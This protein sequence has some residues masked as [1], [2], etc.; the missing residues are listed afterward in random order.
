MPMTC[1]V[2]G[3]RNRASKKDNIQYFSFPFKDERR[4]MAWINAINRPQWTPT[5]NSRICSQHFTRN[6]YLDRPGGYVK[7]LKYNA[8]PS[9]FMSS[10]ELQQKELEEKETQ[11]I[12]KENVDPNMDIDQTIERDNIQINISN[13]DCS[14]TE[15]SEENVASPGPSYLVFPPEEFSDNN[16]I[17]SD[18]S[19]DDNT[20]SSHKE[21]KL[22]YKV[23]ILQQQ[24]RRKNKKIDSLKQLLTDLK[25]QGKIEDDVMHLVSNEF[26]G[27]PFEIFKNQLLNCKETSSKAYRY[28]DAVKQFALTLHF[29]SPKAYQYCRN[30]GLCLPN[31]SS[32]RN[33]TM[34]VNAEPGF[35]R[36][37]FSALKQLNDE[38]RDCNLVFDSMAI[39]KQVMWDKQC[40]KYIGYCN[41][42][43][44]LHL[45]G[46]DT[47]ATEALVF[48]LVGINGKW[49]WPIGY[50]F[51]DKIKAVIQAELIKTALIL[52]GDAGI[53]I[54]R[55]ILFI[56][57]KVI[58]YM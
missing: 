58:M 50:F 5:K 23:R 25:A 13:T 39:R 16:N 49:K 44:E 15:Y 29:Y 22:R 38:D 37:V 28:T 54:L 41:Y 52:A 47:V 11:D 26:D 46:S 19:L 17:D 31:P 33:W 7:H 1:C 10:Y 4:L 55:I 18:D 9:V 51:I 32:L 20:G 12:N 2:R 30:I 27:V 40:Q 3:C 8:V 45:E 6:D 34:S 43:N 21:L 36:D 14:Y 35:Q 48:M 24:V 42:G 53:R 56:Q 57:L